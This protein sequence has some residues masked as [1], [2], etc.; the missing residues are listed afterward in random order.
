MA[1]FKRAQVQSVSIAMVE[2]MS[3]E[4]ICF[5]MF[6]M[7]LRNCFGGF[8]MHLDAATRLIGFVW[9]SFV[10]RLEILRVSFCKSICQVQLSFLALLILA[11]TG[12]SHIV[13]ALQHRSS[14]V[15]HFRLLALALCMNQLITCSQL[16]SVMEQV[17]GI[18]LEEP[19]VTGTL[20]EDGRRLCSRF[21][22][23]A[24]FFTE[25][26]VGVGKP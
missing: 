6:S 9:K 1:F 15:L 16:F 10:F 4:L 7:V 12:G 26:C 5:F 20:G 8:D 14:G 24:R 18:V 23:T 25:T 19:F 2:T 21:R 13:F 22:Q 17:Q 11:L 3:L